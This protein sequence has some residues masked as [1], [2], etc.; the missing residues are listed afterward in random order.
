MPLGGF[1]VTFSDQQLGEAEPQAVELGIEL[2]GRGVLEYRFV[3]TSFLFEANS[4]LRESALTELGQGTR[5][6]LEKGDRVGP[7]A[8]GPVEEAEVVEI[9]GLGRLAFEERFQ[10]RTLLRGQETVVEEL[11]VDSHGLLDVFIG[12]LNLSGGSGRS[13][14]GEGPGRRNDPAR[15]EASPQT[16]A[17]AHFFER[18]SVF[19][20]KTAHIL[21]SCALDVNLRGEGDILALT[22]Y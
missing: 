11:P 2:E 10:K 1:E 18:V 17:H 5:C 12:V 4:L 21:V 13:G 19:C 22:S 20:S 9:H 14:A 3:L 8:L 7:A 16:R 15:Q 6:T